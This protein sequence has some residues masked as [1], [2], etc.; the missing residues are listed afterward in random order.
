M[1]DAI[2][3]SMRNR[4]EEL[5]RLHAL[6]ETALSDLYERAGLEGKAGFT[7]EMDFRGLQDEIDRWFEA[8]IEALSESPGPTA[9][10]GG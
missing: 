6:W 1:P 8:R 4:K 7:E 5:Q 9:S 2:T 3:H 10:K